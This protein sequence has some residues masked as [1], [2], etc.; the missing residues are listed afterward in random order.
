MRRRTCDTYYFFA[1]EFPLACLGCLSSTRQLSPE[2]YQTRSPDHIRH[3]LCRKQYII[4]TEIAKLL[5]H[6][7]YWSSALLETS[8]CLGDFLCQL[9]YNVNGHPTRRS[10]EA[11]EAE[12]AKKRNAQTKC[13]ASGKV[14]ASFI[15]RSLL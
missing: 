12:I 4:C 6:H 11:R 8:P 15:N 7:C 3:P 9:L 2:G 14:V 1:L 13:K 5:F 10:G